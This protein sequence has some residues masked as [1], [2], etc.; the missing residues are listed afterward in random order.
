[1]MKRLRRGLVRLLP[2]FLLS[3]AASLAL[4]GCGRPEEPN[5]SSGYQS[6]SY[7]FCFWNVENLFDDRNDNRHGADAAYDRWF[8]EDAR[9][10]EEKYAHLSQALLK[11]NDGRGPD[12]LA[13]AEVESVRAAELLRDALN[14]H[15]P[16]D[17]PPYTH[18]LMKDL[19]AGRHIATAI[20]TRLPVQQDRTHLLGR[21][22]RI[23]EGHITVNKHDLVILAT[24]WTSRL[25]DKSG[26]HRCKYGDQI[27]GRFLGMYKNNP[28]VD[29]LICGDFNDNPTDRS[30]TDCLHATGDVDAFRR[31]A[32]RDRPLLL[33]LLAAPL[34]KTKEVQGR[35]SIPGT[36]YDRGRWSIFDQIV[37]SP[38]MLDDEGWHCDPASA[39]IFVDDLLRRTRRGVQ[40]W[41]FGNRHQEGRRGYSD[42]LPVTVRLE[43]SGS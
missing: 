36:E 9:D 42:H 33:D 37:V 11:M 27:Y 26:S 20:L 25:T 3:T 19:N 23:L 34:F 24:H 5:L 32:T 30:V 17:V 18:V 14:D 35:W 15:L 21:S 6:D 2:V 4:L 31:A 1:M 28:K 43:L 29:L 38:G 7:L 13:V 12:I 22:L 41:R 40:P 8:A 10:R 39:A 16:A